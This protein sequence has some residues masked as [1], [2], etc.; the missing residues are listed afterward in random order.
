VRLAPARRPQVPVGTPLDSIAVMRQ[1]RE[2]LDIHPLGCLSEADLPPREGWVPGGGFQENDAKNFCPEDPVLDTELKGLHESLHAGETRAQLLIDTRLLACWLATTAPGL[3]RSVPRESLVP[4]PASAH[5]HKMLPDIGRFILQSLAHRD[6]KTNLIVN[7]ICNSMPCLKRNRVAFLD[8]DAFAHPHAA[9]LINILHGL[10][11]GLY[12]STAKRPAFR[13]RVRLAGELR[14]LLCAPLRTQA[15]FLQGH[16]PLLKLSM[17]EYLWHT[18]GTYLTTELDAISHVH[19]MGT[20]MEIC[21]N[22]CDGFRQEGLQEASWTWD[23]L[24][25]T[26][27]TFVERCVRTC[28]F[29]M[30][31]ARADAEG[32]AFWVPPWKPYP[33]RVVLPGIP[34]QESLQ[35]PLH[36]PGGQAPP[37]SYIAKANQEP[38]QPPQAPVAKWK[39]VAPTQSHLFEVARE[40]HVAQAPGVLWSVYAD[41]HPELTVEDFHLIEHLHSRCRVHPLPCN[42]AATQARMLLE[43]YGQDHA[44]LASV[45]R[46]H[47]CLRC[48]NKPNADAIATKLRLC[49][50]T[51]RLICVSCASHLPVVAVDLLGKVLVVQGV[52]YY[53]CP[54]CG[55]CKRWAFSGTEFTCVDCRHRPAPT[56]PRPAPRRCLHCSKTNGLERDIFLFTELGVKVQVSLCSKHA[57]PAHVSRFVTDVGDYCRAARACQ[58]EQAEARK[59]RGRRR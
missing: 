56:P 57:L 15:E 40:M 28:K 4:H 17:M 42:L 20:F 13:C 46:V 59:C 54:I 35:E 21:P 33:M 37:F 18:C 38:P 34:H 29:R 47:L 9:V 2:P 58:A 10:L 44:Q 5:H 19:G 49:M 39:R 31:R 8:K 36:T 12:P 26:A 6:W 45:S 53:L 16:L 55:G 43:T 52:T 1:G 27:A 22:I 24:S 3:Y 32:H 30:G 41:L 48:C 23:S 51:G 50:H 11:L 14:A 7:V 25:S